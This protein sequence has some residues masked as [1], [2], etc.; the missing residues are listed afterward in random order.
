MGNVKK[1][2]VTQPAGSSR[3]NIVP[4]SKIEAEVRRFVTEHRISCPEAIEQNED[5]IEDAPEFIENLINI[6]GYYRE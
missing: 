5:V 6:V 1:K 4:M 2:T 3:K